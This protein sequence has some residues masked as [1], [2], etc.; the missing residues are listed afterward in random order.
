MTTIVLGMDGMD[1]QIVEENIDEFPNLSKLNVHG[2]DSVYPPITI[3]AWPC[4]FSGLE[5]DKLGVFDFQEIDYEDYSFSFVDNSRFS[6]EAFWDHLDEK[7]A[8]I[9][10]PGA[11]TQEINGFSIGD[12]FYSESLNTYPESLKEELKEQVDDIELERIG[13]PST[14]KGK[15]KAAMRNFERRKKIFNHLLEKDVGVIFTVFRLTD[16]IMHHCDTENEMVE[17][18][19]RVDRF[20]GGLIDSID[21]EDDLLIV[22]DHG[23]ARAEKRFYINRFLEEEGFLERNVEKEDGGWDRL[24][25][26]AGEVAQRLGLRDFVVS[27]NNLIGEKTGKSFSPSKSDVMASIDFESTRAFSFMTGVSHYAGVWINDDR[28]TRGIVDNSEEVIQSV[29]NSL[30]ERSEVK[31]VFRKEELYDN[32]VNEFP[33]LVVEFYDRVKASFGFHPQVTSKV[34]TYIHRKE[35]VLMHNKESSKSREDYDCKLV[36][37]APT[38]LNLQENRIPEDLDGKA[39]GFLSEESERYKE[40]VSDLDI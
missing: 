14:E 34:A 40:R 11:D 23:A 10:V 16:T 18:Y 20:I 22:S 2:L 28:F 24:I 1:K 13:D 32:R 17:A 37:L 15:R 26:K 7:A 31:Q 9:G 19:S 6:D 33:D 4:A 35:G 3:P 27:L 36:D 25:L 29:Q 12:L 5:P 30:E 8:I 21:E 38:I 39:I